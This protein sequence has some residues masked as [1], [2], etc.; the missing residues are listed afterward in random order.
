MW[1]L[2][3]PDGRVQSC[4]LRANSKTVAGWDL[5]VL[6]GTEILV[7]LKGANERY[8]WLVAENTRRDLLRKGYK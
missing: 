5:Q 6:E 4:R 3:H 2:S 8:A 7:T 1:R